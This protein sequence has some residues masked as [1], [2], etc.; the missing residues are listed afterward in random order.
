[1][2]VCGLGVKQTLG[3]AMV[4]LD[5][6]HFTPEILSHEFGTVA[7]FFLEEFCSSQA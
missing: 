4:L 3:F 1:M 7:K 5:H 2:A 6:I